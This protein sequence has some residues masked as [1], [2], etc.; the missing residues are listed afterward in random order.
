MP[1]TE[2]QFPSYMYLWEPLRKF[3][4]R[5]PQR[6]VYVRP[7]A[8]LHTHVHN[9][10]AGYSASSEFNFSSI[11]PDIFCGFSCIFNTSAT[12]QRPAHGTLS[13]QEAIHLGTDSVCRGL[14]SSWI[15]SRDYCIV[16]R[17]AIFEPLFYLNFSLSPIFYFL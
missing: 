13:S 16:V 12:P 15:R 3:R 1:D 8:A 14:G 4:S 2:V 10:P 6:L 11:F 7:G 17:C 9:T 5:A